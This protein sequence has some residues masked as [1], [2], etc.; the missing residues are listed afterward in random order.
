MA[1]PRPN[2]KVEPKKDNET[3]NTVAPIEPVTTVE[4]V[5]DDTSVAPVMT[6]APVTPKV[7]KPRA[8]SVTVAHLYR[9][10]PIEADIPVPEHVPGN[11]GRQN[12]YPF[13]K[14]I[15]NG[16]SFFVPRSDVNPFPA[17]RLGSTVARMNKK[18]R[19]LGYQFVCQPYT[20]QQADG[21]PIEGARVWRVA[22]TK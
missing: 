10:V 19:P 3:M 8:P 13:G 1:K 2:V 5:A 11:R 7:R 15:A 22:Y 20:H 14:L 18:V 12:G 9:N 4:P 17:E 21:T 6:D 16:Q